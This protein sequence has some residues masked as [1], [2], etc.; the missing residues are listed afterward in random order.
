MPGSR[1][2][3]GTGTALL[4][5]VYVDYGESRKFKSVRRTT[6]QITLDS[7]A[8]PL[9]GIWLNVLRRKAKLKIHPV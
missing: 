3:T 5:I 9:M 2:F 7:G 8:I 6:R 1:K 4:V